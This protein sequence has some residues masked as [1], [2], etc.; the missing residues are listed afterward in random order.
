MSGIDDWR[1]ITD[2]PPLDG[3]EILLGWRGDPE[4]LTGYW[5]SEPNHWDETGW[6][7]EDARQGHYFHRH[8]LKPTHW[9]PLPEGPA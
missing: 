2:D 6:Q 5:E 7:E 8:P 4:P 3:T 1:L 9:R